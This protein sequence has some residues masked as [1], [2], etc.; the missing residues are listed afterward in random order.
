MASVYLTEPSYEILPRTD[1]FVLTLAQID[2]TVDEGSA[3][4]FTPANNLLKT[5]LSQSI[6]VLFYT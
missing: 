6:R 5:F 1:V 3:H 4:L 2:I